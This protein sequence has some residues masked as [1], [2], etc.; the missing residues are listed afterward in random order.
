MRASRKIVY[1]LLTLFLVSLFD[2]SLDHRLEQTIQHATH[3]TQ[4]HMATDTHAHKTHTS[5]TVRDVRGS[6]HRGLPLIWRVN[7]SEPTQGGTRLPKNAPRHL[8]TPR[9]STRRHD[10]TL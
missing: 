10:E 6:F 1:L 2:A 3:E 4:R 8:E 5:Q 7:P 9:D